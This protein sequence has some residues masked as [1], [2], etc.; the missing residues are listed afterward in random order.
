MDQQCPAIAPG[1]V[2]LSPLTAARTHAKA[3]LVKTKPGT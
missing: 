1:I 2:T 3:A